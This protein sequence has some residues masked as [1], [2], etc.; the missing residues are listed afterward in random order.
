MQRHRQPHDPDSLSLADLVK[1]VQKQVT[2]DIA[3]LLRQM[4]GPTSELL[5]LA[6]PEGVVAADSLVTREENAEMFRLILRELQATGYLLT[7]ITEAADANTVAEWGN[8]DQVPPD[9]RHGIV[10]MLVVARGARNVDYYTANIEHP[11]G[12]ATKLGPWLQEE[13]IRLEPPKRLIS[14]W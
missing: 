3:E 2:L 13:M 14:N 6:S 1:E 12:G 9:D 4:S 11:T 5:M 8:L 10:V 7:M